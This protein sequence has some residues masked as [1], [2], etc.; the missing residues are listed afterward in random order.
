MSQTIR[1]RDVEGRRIMISSTAD[2]GHS[3]VSHFNEQKFQFWK[4]DTG[5][6][7]RVS[8][9]QCINEPH[10]LQTSCIADG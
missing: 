2:I 9:E 8:F 3:F 1:L 4:I 10:Y 7:P 5:K 6:N